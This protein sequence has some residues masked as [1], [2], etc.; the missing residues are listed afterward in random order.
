MNRFPGITHHVYKDGNISAI[1]YNSK[2][3]NAVQTYTY[4]Y[5]NLNRLTDA[6]FAPDNKY[7]ET[8]SYDKN[9]NITSLVRQGKAG[10]SYT[11]IDNLTYA[12]NGNQLIGVNDINS[13]NYQANGF[14][15][16]GLFRNAVASNPA[17]HEYFYDI[18]GNMVKDYNK[19]V[20]RIVYNY[21]NLPQEMSVG[22]D[23]TIYYLYT[24]GGSKLRQTT[25]QW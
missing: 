16:N 14:T 2:N 12:Y 17:S 24:A 6:T 9:G 22:N 23:T 25:S 1:Q 19:P 13:T 4:Q 5:D 3:L 11:T 7:N 18:N 8:I 15:D 20:E 10:S 21:L